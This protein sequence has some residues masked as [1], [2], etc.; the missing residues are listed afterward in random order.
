LCATF[1]A[2]SSHAQ[3]TYAS[4]VLADKPVAYWRLDETDGTTLNDYFSVHTGQYNGGFTLQQPGCLTFDSDTAV[5]LD[6][7]GYAQVP[8]S[9]AL[10]STNFT[11]ELWVYPTAVSGL[12][13]PLSSRNTPYGP[14][15]AMFYANGGLWQFAI[16]GGPA[17]W[18]NIMGPAVALNQWTHLVGTFDG[19]TQA[20]Y[21]N[22]Q[23]V[24]SQGAVLSPNTEAPL[25]IGAG[26]NDGS[27]QFKWPGLIDEVAIYTNA[28]T[29]AQ[30]HD[31]YLLGTFGT[32]NDSPPVIK[33]QPQPLSLYV[34]S[35]ASFTVQAV[36]T[37]PMSY[38]WRAGATGSGT[39]TN[40][41][42][43]NN[44][45]GSTT[46]TLTIT[47]L[48]LVNAADYLVVITNAIG[49]VTSSVAT[50]TVQSALPP[51]IMLEPRSLNLYAGRTASFSV[52]AESTLPM[53]Y[54]WRAGAAGSGTYT[55][56]TD[57]SNLF[58]STTSRLSITN[59]SL[60]NADM[61]CLVVITNA[62][63]S[64]TSIGVT[65]T[66]QPAP[67]G[68]YASAV[69]S[70]N[71][72]AYWRLDEA[73]GTM[74]YDFA[75]GHN[76][77]YN[78]GVAL[79]QP[80][81]STY[82]TDPAAS[83]F[84]S[85][86]GYASVPYSADLNPGKFSVECWVY[87]TGGAGNYRSPFSNRYQN[88]GGHGYLLYAND[89]DKWSFW[90]GA[91]PGA[92]I[93]EDGVPVVLNQWTHLVGTFDGTNQVLYVNGQQL[94]SQQAVYSPNTFA[95]LNI[96]RGANDESGNFYWRGSVDEVA[97]YATPLTAT[98]V[99][100]H[101]L[102]GAFGTIATPPLIVRDPRS[103]DL[104]AGRTASFTVQAAS[105]LP[106]S[107]RWMAGATGSGTFTNLADASNLSGATTAT[108]N[109]L[110]VSPANVADYLVVVANAS[111]SVTS[112]VATLAVQ[113]APAGAYANA[114]LAANPVAYW[115]LDEADGTVLNDYAGGHSGL[116]NGGVNLN[117]PGYSTYDTD[118]AA[119]VFD[120]NPGYASVPYYA[121]LNPP[122]FSVEC[123]VYPTGG[124]GNYRSPFSNRYINNGGNGY[125]LYADASDKWSF[126]TGNSPGAWV[127][128]DG[129]AVV[130]NQ[131]THLV[132]S[133]DGTHQVLY[134]DGQQ[135]VS[136]P[137]TLSVNTAAPLNIGRGAND[138]SGAFYWLGRVDE[139]AV[140]RA[141][142]SASQVLDHYVLA[143]TGALP[144][145]T[146][147]YTFSS[148][149]LTLTWANG[150]LLQAPSVL[151]PWTTNLVTSPF[152]VNSTNAQ[153]YY[154][155]IVN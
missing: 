87:P 16:G 100:E 13:S 130:L 118:T 74:L 55:N 143:T 49:A 68:A 91:S 35:T 103:L 138:Q 97:I 14:Q 83:F 41:A 21:I 23:S 108:L 151:G 106:L 96:G 25:N 150:T 36:S 126:W 123:W 144:P 86:P 92:W 75:G 10:N 137:A 72:M 28:L 81:Y 57:A 53:S 43:A 38:Q 107:H 66:V 40:L 24:G 85:S 22:G 60:A 76:G 122:V 4:A 84:D 134:V 67:V 141:P 131:W 64:V 56:L 17:S 89:Q 125:L 101:Y 8:Y 127:S 29:A 152:D 9:E 102:L 104:Y 133:Y 48:S 146:L 61:D 50:L 19:H 69:L 65:L 2:Q 58:G 18:Q 5:A 110:N 121:D 3:S 70:A 105:S 32:V 20:L 26:V 132:G 148:G 113:P 145:Q 140:Y 27:A 47:N 147:Q 30:V 111:G 129:P 149:K 62:A 112:T 154:R 34:G 1:A 39:H 54:Q 11:V 98:Q 73:D 94:A 52:Q 59:I 117:Q 33:H 44:L 114:V 7:T 78:G 142:L 109:V 120:P 99:R 80:G 124:A 88:N 46:P 77:D 37:L 153:M 63:G 82:D 155:L 135:V 136:Q 93:S 128:V 71:P 31:H 116:Y 119:S 12:Y 90:L 79:N 51:V 115:R 6:G 45:S 95:P 139:V 42:D 15:G